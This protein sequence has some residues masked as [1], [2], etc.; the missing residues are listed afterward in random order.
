MSFSCSNHS[1]IVNFWGRWRLFQFYDSKTGLWCSLTFLPLRSFFMDWSSSFPP[2]SG[3]LSVTEIHQGIFLFLT[4]TTHLILRILH[5]LNSP[6]WHGANKTSGQDLPPLLCLDRLFL[7]PRG[8]SSSLGTCCSV[9]SHWRHCA[10]I[11]LSQL[12]WLLH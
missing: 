12:I 10:V 11:L 9:M 5:P 2:P 3:P 4:S 7:G 8:S 1:R 6:C